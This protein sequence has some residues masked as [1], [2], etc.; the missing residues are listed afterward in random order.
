M[1]QKDETDRRGT[2]KWD[3]KRK[4]NRYSKINR[5]E[6]QMRREMRQ[7]DETDR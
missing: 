6:C 7:T 2:V 1:Q 3:R 5:S 4:Q